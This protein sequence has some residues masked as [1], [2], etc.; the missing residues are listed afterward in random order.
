MDEIPLHLSKW[1]ERDAEFVNSSTQELDICP[2]HY[3]VV[4]RCIQ[5]QGQA[6]GR[7]GIGKV[8]YTYRCRPERW[9]MALTDVRTP[10]TDRRTAVAQDVGAVRVCGSERSQICAAECLHRH[11]RWRSTTII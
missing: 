8:R 1:Y 7:P 2:V 4:I 3:C 11:T 5:C 6:C 10:S 9:A